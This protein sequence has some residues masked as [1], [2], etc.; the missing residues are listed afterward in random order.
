[1]AVF[2][3]FDL[4]NEESLTLKCIQVIFRH[5]ARTPLKHLPGIDE[6]SN[7]I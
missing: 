4:V 5:G 2:L 7:I 6:V 1:M 3:K